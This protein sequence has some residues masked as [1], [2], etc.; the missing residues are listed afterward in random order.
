M[1]HVVAAFRKMPTFAANVAAEQMLVIVVLPPQ[2][3][4][5]LLLTVSTTFGLSSNAVHV[6]LLLPHDR[7]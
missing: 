6:L 7:L 2:G 4:Y 5:I 1:A 3:F